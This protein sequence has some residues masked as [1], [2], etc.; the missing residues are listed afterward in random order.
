MPTHSTQCEALGA[1]L[2]PLLAGILHLAKPASVHACPCPNPNW[3]RRFGE[4]LQGVATIRAFS[5]ERHVTTRM[6]GLLEAN[7]NALLAQKRAMGW[8]ATRLDALG[9]LVLVLTGHQGCA[10]AAYQAAVLQVDAETVLHDTPL[11]CTPS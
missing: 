3:P 1:C 6:H 5:L 8:L 11:A 4:A 10:V 2:T 9:I 7:A